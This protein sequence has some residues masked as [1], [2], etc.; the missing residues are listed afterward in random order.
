MKT[1]PQELPAPTGIKTFECVVPVSGVLDVPFDDWP[2]N[3]QDGFYAAA[4]RLSEEHEVP[5]AIVY[6]EYKTD[7]DLPPE[8]PGYHYLHVILS[9]VVVADQRTLEPG[10]VLNEMPDDIKRLLN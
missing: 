1:L 4:E 7:I 8:A 10:R 6:A 3:I 9:E 5:V 2:A